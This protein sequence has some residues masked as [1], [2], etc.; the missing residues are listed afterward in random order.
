[1][2]DCLDALKDSLGDRIDIAVP[3]GDGDG[4]IVSIDHVVDGEFG[5]AGQSPPTGDISTAEISHVR[6][7]NIVRH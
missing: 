7:G 1:M 5:P 6:S 3:D 4:V 2:G